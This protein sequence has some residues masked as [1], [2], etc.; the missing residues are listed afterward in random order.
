MTIY[1]P[2]DHSVWSTCPLSILHR[3]PWNSIYL[4]W[5]PLS[6]SFRKCCLFQHPIL[7]TK[8]AKNFEGGRLDLKILLNMKANKLGN[9]GFTEADKRYKTPASETKVSNT[10]ARVSAFAPSPQTSAPKSDFKKVY[11]LGCI[12][13]RKPKE[14]IIGSKHTCPFPQREIL[15]LSDQIVNKYALCPR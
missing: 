15:S 1:C 7:F 13:E 3:I 6:S 10:V 2:V 12:T 14:P 9:H 4:L 11:A 8:T 5:G